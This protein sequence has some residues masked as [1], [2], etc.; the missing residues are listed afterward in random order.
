MAFMAISTIPSPAEH[1][2]SGD[3]IMQIGLGTIGAN[4]FLIPKDSYRIDKKLDDGLP[5]S[6][7]VTFRNIATSTDAL[8]TNTTTSYYLLSNTIGCNLIVS[9]D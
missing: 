6:G 1:Y 2:N 4:G 3:N 8:C 5:K 7:T 9:V